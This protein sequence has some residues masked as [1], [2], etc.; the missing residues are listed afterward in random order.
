MLL[1]VSKHRYYVA[2][3]TVIIALLSCFFRI[4]LCALGTNTARLYFGFD[5]RIDGLMVRCTLGI[6]ISSELIADNLKTILSKSIVII[7]PL[8]AVA[9]FGFFCI[10]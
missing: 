5:T 4:F 3:A 7:A 9:L 1:R 2:I 10:V 8:S 6:A